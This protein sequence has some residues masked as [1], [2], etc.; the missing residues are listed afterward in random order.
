VTSRPEPC[1]PGP[2]R[3]HA[4][5][6]RTLGWDV[7]YL[8]V[9]VAVLVI[10]LVSSPGSR[11]VAGGAMGAMIAWYLFVGRP[12][13]ADAGSPWAITRPSPRRAAIYVTG[14][15]SLFFVVQGNNSNAW[16][17]AFALSPQFFALLDGRTAIWVSVA[18]NLMAAAL[19]VYRYPSAG[20]AVVALALAAAGG[21][22][23]VFYGRWVSRII[24]QSAERAGMIDQ[25][26]ATRAELAAAQH[27]AGRLAERQRLAAEI[28]DTLAQGFTSILMLIQAA[29]A[30]LGGSHPQAARHMDSA[31]RTA[32]ENLA[33]ARALVAGLT[34]AQLD[35]GTLPDALRRLS[36]ASSVDA[37]F[38]LTGTPRPLPTATE[39]VLLR[40]CQ[41]A[42]SNVRKH[43]RAQSAAVLLDYDQD[44]VRL[45]VSDDGA[46]FDPAS[47]NGGF[48]L[49]GMRARV[50][51]AG[52]T[53]TVGSEPG[54]GTHISARVPS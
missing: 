44:T 40:V 21:G 32:R 52:G 42:L 33:E 49:R 38:R 20:T 30:D 9:F 41:E 10:V 43:A 46:G 51:E 7:F 35:G 54:A 50:A 12:M 34:P 53:L 45:E 18:L 22:F 39:V 1:D 14:L 6:T 29:Q 2:D 48:G 15:F 23:S 17:L 24:E 25:L 8:L 27:E 11:A 37:S 28:H 3:R 13:W 19:L 26:E 47:A 5:E 4:W 31:A 16:L 36:N